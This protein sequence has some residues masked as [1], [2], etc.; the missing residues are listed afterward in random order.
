MFVLPLLGLPFSCFPRS[1]VLMLS[2]VFPQLNDQMDALFD[3][4]QATRDE[5]HGQYMQAIDKLLA[6][7][8]AKKAKA[9]RRHRHHGRKVSGD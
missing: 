4:V 8:H 7:H 6:H 2:L 9:E 1:V 3:K 5:T